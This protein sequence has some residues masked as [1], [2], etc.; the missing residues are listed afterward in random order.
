MDSDDKVKSM[1]SELYIYISGV[2]S[3]GHRSEAC[4]AKHGGQW[5]PSELHI[6]T[7]YICTGGGKKKVAIIENMVNVV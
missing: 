7:V 4:E 1:I 2:R 5:C 6:Y 3:L